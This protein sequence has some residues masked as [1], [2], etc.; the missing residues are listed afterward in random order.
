MIYNNRYINQI[1]YV[2]NHILLG[3]SILSINGANNR[4]RMKLAKYIG[5]RPKHLT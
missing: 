2:D 1:E 4:F 3:L 5:G